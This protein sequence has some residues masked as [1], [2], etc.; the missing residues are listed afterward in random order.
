[1]PEPPLVARAV[2]E[3]PAPP[4]IE[5]NLVPYASEPVDSGKP[6]DFD[7]V[8]SDSHNRTALAP[9]TIQGGPKANTRAAD[10]SNPK[11]EKAEWLFNQAQR[12]QGDGALQK[13]SELW[14]QFL[15]QNL[16]LPG[17][18]TAVYN[19]GYCLYYLGRAQEALDPLKNMIL[20]T[21]D[22]KLIN[23]A[24]ILLAESLLQTGENEEA[25][26]TTFDVLPD[27]AAEAA[28]G[29]ERSSNAVGTAENSEG[30][31]LTQKIRLYTI[32]GRIFASL[33]KENQ[34]HAALEHAKQLLLHAE[35]GQINPTDMRFLSGNYAWRQMEVQAL[36]C[37]QRVVIPERLSEAEFLTY[38]DAYYGCAS[39]ARHLYCTVLAARNE[40]IRSQAQITYRGLIEAPLEIRNHLPPP[41]REIR[42]KEQRSHYES[43]MKALIEKTV[44]DR[45]RDFKDL[46]SCHAHDVF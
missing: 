33:K 5:S 18:N 15:D 24:R 6:F 1:A 25:L 4:K 21:Q 43:E 40:Q 3:P 8:T 14:K 37:Q 22:S 27:H 42:K 9:Q 30:P 36:S 35:K 46:P 17:Y 39:P 41:A 26:A 34:A 11:L 32:R 2:P 10:A 31:N 16:G 28:A 13:A 19:Y 29:L 45:V 44:N 12:Q 20:E 23:D 38:A 7:G